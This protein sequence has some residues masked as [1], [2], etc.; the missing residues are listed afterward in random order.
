MKL[1]EPVQ[2][3]LLAL[4]APTGFKVVR[5]L[6][7]ADHGRGLAD[8]YLPKKARAGTP[9]AVFIYGGSWDSGATGVSTASWAR[10]WLRRGS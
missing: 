3:L 1:P 2:R 4:A 9:I 7:Y 6:R 10:P 5:G 8:V